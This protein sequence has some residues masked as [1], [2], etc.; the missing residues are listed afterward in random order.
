MSQQ[1]GR[2]EAVR[3]AISR[4]SGV[5][6]ENRLQA[7]GLPSSVNGT[8]SIRA[9]GQDFEIDL[10]DLS[11]VLPKAGK[12]ASLSDRILILHYLCCEGPISLSTKLI[13]FRS[14]TGGQFYL[15]PFHSRTAKPLIA[16]IENNLDLLKKNLDRFDWKPASY[17]DFS[18]KIHAIGNLF[19]TLVY[20]IGDDEFPPSCEVLFDES[21]GRAYEAEDA[22]ALASRICL[23]LL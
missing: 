11:V 1:E 22:A 23:G 6:L 5:A 20:S 2:E 8:L 4:L 21:T 9:F 13:S 12:P 17:G 7:L 18:A 14:F 19:I 10:E 15:Q 16:K 3:K